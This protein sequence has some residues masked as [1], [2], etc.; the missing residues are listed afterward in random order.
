MTKKEYLPT[1]SLDEEY[2]YFGYGLENKKWITKLPTYQRYHS[3]K[4]SNN[5]LVTVIIANYNNSR[6]LKKMMDSLVKQ[7]IGLKNMQIIFVDDRSTDDSLDIIRE[8]LIK[9]D[10]I[11]IIAFDENT[12]GAHGPRNQG[13]LLAKGKYVVFLDADDWYSY[14]GIETLVNLLESSGDSFGVS[15]ISYIRHGEV[16]V[17]SPAYSDREAKNRKYNDL[18]YEFYNWLGPQGIILETKL[19][20]DNNLHFVDQR[21]ADDVT[22]F[23]EALR[24]SRTISQTPQFTTYV[25]RDSDNVSLTKRLG[26]TFM[27]SWLRSLSYLY[28]NFEFDASM[29][30]FLAKRLEWLVIDFCLRKDT[31]FGFTEESLNK[32]K[33]YLDYYLGNLPFD[34]S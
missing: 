10:S 2:D 23:Y 11:E 20:I 24:L 22:F 12:G 9:Y 6:Y 4:L 28:K 8:Y 19:V 7:T 17:L 32:F 26:E 34:Q 21:V 31:D 3:K 33:D 13:L 14:N 1:S 27:V 30:L 16:S 25:N 18:P 15:K 29:Q 5:P